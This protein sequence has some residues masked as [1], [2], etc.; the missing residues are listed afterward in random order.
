MATSGSSFLHQSLVACALLLASSASATVTASLPSTGE[1]RFRV[2]LGER[3]IGQHRFVVQSR[4]NA[5]EVRSEARFAVKVL[6]FN[7]FSYTHDAAE[8]WGGECLDRIESRTD[9]NGQPYSVLGQRE[10]ASFRVKTGTAAVEL[11][12]C[13]MSFAYWNPRMLG[14][15]RLLNA[16]TGELVDV[17]IEARGEESIQAAGGTVTARR[18]ALT[19]RNVSIDLW[20]GPDGRWVGL[21]SLTEGGR[22]LRYVLH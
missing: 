22:R 16:Q 20:Y 12:A 9:H 4:G 18:Y 17:K 8:T 19:G 6:G 14:E 7:A 21:E 5:R 13:L 2:F 15:T 3:E 10:P 11:P 1:W